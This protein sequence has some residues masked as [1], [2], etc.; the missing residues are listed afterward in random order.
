MNTLTKN[1]PRLLASAIFFALALDVCPGP[2]GQ[3][4]PVH[5]GA[6][7]QQLQLGI[8]FTRES[9]VAGEP[10]EARILT[11]NVT[12]TNVLWGFDRCYGPNGAFY[13]G[14]G[15]VVTQGTNVARSLVNRITDPWSPALGV[16]SSSL[17]EL[18]PGGVQEYT[19][20]L[21]KEFALKPDETYAVTASTGVRKL[22]GKGSAEIKTGTAIIKIVQPLPALTQT[23]RENGSVQEK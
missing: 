16:S 19:V 17:T 22:E 20:R 8:Q 15:I 23:N 10:V 4:P 3:S 21:D 2:A 18:T 9:F 1:T 11:R 5:W 13:D 7:G 14:Y 12:A 6:P